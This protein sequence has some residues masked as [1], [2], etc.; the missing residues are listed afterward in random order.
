MLSPSQMGLN[1]SF[2]T[3]V[4]SLAA[5][6]GR[7]KRYHCM[8]QGSFIPQCT[9]KGCCECWEWRT[10]ATRFLE[11]SWYCGAKVVGSPPKMKQRRGGEEHFCI[12]LKSVA[13][14]K[15]ESLR[16]YFALPVL[17]TKAVCRKN[18]LTSWLFDR[19]TWLFL[20]CCLWEAK[21]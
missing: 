13:V 14:H 18:S 1:T 5:G 7:E 6:P 16:G 15:F 4:N 20:I 17:S 10:K 9:G 12:L 21:D 8:W 3:T 19:N 11:E 2:F